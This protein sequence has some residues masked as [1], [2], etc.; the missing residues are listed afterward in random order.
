MAAMAILATCFYLFTPKETESVR[1]EKEEEEEMEGEKAGYF[2]ARMRYEYDMLKDPA[3]GTIPR[4][5]FDKEVEFAKTLPVR[6][7]DFLPLT[8]FGSAKEAANNSYIPA[9]PYNIGGRT[10]AAAYDVRYGVSNNVII[11]GCVSGGIMR[12][13]DGGVNWTLVTPTNNDVHSFTALAQ[14]PR[15]GFQDT[16]YAAGGEF[17][18]NSA[19]EL[20][21]PYRGFGIWKSV[22]NGATWT[23]LATTTGTSTSPIETFDSIFDYVYRIVV[24]PVNGD[25]YV[26]AYQSISRSVNGG[27]TF[28]SVFAPATF[29]SAT[30]TNSQ[31]EVAISSTGKVFV[32]INGG[33]QTT[34]L[35]GVWVS[36]TGDLN[37]YTRIAGG[38]TLGVDSVDGWRGNS[39]SGFN[40]GGTT[41]YNSKRILLAVAPSNPNIAYVYYEN[42]LSSDAPSLKPEADFFR[43]DI[44][45]STYTWNNRSA[46]MPDFAGNNLSGS[47]PLS[48]QGGYD[49]MV[50]VKPN[51]PNFVVI[52][53]TNLYRSTDGFASVSNTA[54]IGGYQNN[55]TYSQYPN[56]HADI[57]EF[58]FNQNNPSEAL[59]GNDGGIQFTQDILAG[60]VTWTLPGN[61]QTLQ[62]YRVD[63]DPGEGRNNFA[64]AAQDNGIRLRDKVGILG[65]AAVDS[66]NHKLF[67][68]ADGTCVALAKTG[69]DGRQYFYSGVQL[70]RIDRFRLPSTSATTITPSGLTAN[71]DYGSGFGEFVTNFRLDPDNTED[72]YYVN[73]NRLFRTTSAST[74]TA[75]D[76]TELSGVSS[77]I[78]PANGTSVSI[79][80]MA[81]SRGTYATSHALYLGTTNGKIYRLDDPRNAAATTQPVNITPAGLSGNV[82]DIAVNPN[83]DDEIIAVVSNYGVTS[84]WFT[85]NAKNAVPTWVNAEGNLTLPSVRSCAIVVR[86]DAANNPVTE[87]Y[88]GTS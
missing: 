19:A 36:P 87:Y 81:F 49:M 79:R 62:Y 67:F 60:T 52:G 46:N 1:N 28:Q 53:G 80:A 64:G 39:Y 57:H 61:Y 78:S 25:V 82:Q 76:W 51:D 18:G 42:G 11:A 40:S 43:L 17:A 15:P 32:G 35:R 23:K 29:P 83:N 13:T 38:S 44:A 5:I 4:G 3:T 59:C 7:A 34:N 56:S 84:I 30:A 6:T 37:S 65:T 74:V 21:A 10:R 9:G 22:D 66:N 70:G 48:V 54:W 55:F 71:P 14:D 16:W 69:S 68:S 72:L 2:E 73:F 41:I 26:A 75:S 63:I 8:P 12:S 31:T 20:G 45:G 33:F 24:N 58:N 85:R 50:K 77:A 47:D 27:A 88:V 86:K